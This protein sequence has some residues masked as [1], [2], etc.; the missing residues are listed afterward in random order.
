V[1]NLLI[2]TCIALVYILKCPRG[3]EKL[4]Q[5]IEVQMSDCPLELLNS[6]AERVDSHIASCG[7]KIETL[8]N[9]ITGAAARSEELTLDA[10]NLDDTEKSVAA[11]WAGLFGVDPT[12]IEAMLL[13]FKQEKYA[14]FIDAQNQIV[15]SSTLHKTGYE[16]ACAPFSDQKATALDLIAQVA[17]LKVQAADLNANVEAAIALFDAVENPPVIVEEATIS[18]TESVEGENTL[19]SSESVEGDNTLASTE[20]TTSETV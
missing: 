17:A 3:G 13:T 6:V 16:S 12:Q 4:K 11:D 10:A 7:T 1:S 18:S 9:A 20:T 19:A 2:I 8:G 15:S 5:Y 14:P